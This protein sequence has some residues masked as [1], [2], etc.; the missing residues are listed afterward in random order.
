MTNKR[1]RDIRLV[2]GVI[3]VALAVLIGWR[4]MTGLAE[5]DTAWVAQIDLAEGLPL[6]ANDL[7]PVP[8]L[9]ESTRD[10]Y[11]LGEKPPT[12]QVLT[13]R[14]LAGHLLPKDSLALH[15][16]EQVRFVTVGVEPRHSPLATKRGD[17]VDV[18]SSES[19]ESA[20]TLIVSSVPVTDVS[21]EAGGLGSW[22]NG[23]VSLLIEPAQVVEVL[24]A[25]RLGRIDLVLHG[26]KQAG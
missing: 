13:A 24:K 23:R 25:N 9:L 7:A 26:V 5:R 16:L 17:I 12:G 18:Y 19:E 4:V 1:W 8:V 3:F 2:G 22:S 11:W 21:D 14:V 10:T 15:Q 20:P 6:S